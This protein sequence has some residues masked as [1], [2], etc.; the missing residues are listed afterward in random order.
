M[1]YLELLALVSAAATWGDRWR[2]KRVTFHCDCEPVVFAVSKLTSP[3]PNMMH[4]IRTLFM[5]AARSQFEFRVLHIPG[6]TNQVAD[7]LSRGQI[8]RF[9]LLC[10]GSDRSPTIPSPLPILLY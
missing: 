7:A 9:R 5:I 8:D 6:V 2:G 4:L 1:P 3:S 10:P